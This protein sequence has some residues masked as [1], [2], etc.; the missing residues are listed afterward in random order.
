MREGERGSQPPS[1]QSWKGGKTGESVESTLRRRCITE[2]AF[3][4]KEKRRSHSCP[5]RRSRMLFERPRHTL[6][7]RPTR[8]N[9]G[10]GGKGRSLSILGKGTVAINEKDRLNVGKKE[11]MKSERFV[12]S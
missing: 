2:K 7:G 3:H 11:K 6:K 10:R 4:K 9:Q 12:P 8:R 5:K 1:Y